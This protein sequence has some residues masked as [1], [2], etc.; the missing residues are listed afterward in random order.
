METRMDAEEHAKFRRKA[1]YCHFSASKI[2]EAARDFF[3]AAHETIHFIG[4]FYILVEKMDLTLD[5]IRKISGELA[6]PR[7]PMIVYKEAVKPYKEISFDLM[8]ARLIDLFLNYLSELFALIYISK[9]EM[10]RS[11]AEMKVDE[12]LEH[13]TMDELIES[14]AEKKVND[15]AYLGFVKLN[16]TI[17]SQ[18]GESLVPDPSDYREMILAIEF[19]NLFVHNKGIAN[20]TYLNRVDDNSVVLGQKVTSLKTTWMDTIAKIVLEIDSRFAD[21]FAIE[22]ITS[23]SPHLCYAL[24]TV[25]DR[26]SEA[27]TLLSKP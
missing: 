2:T 12:I 11:S 23:Y 1:V 14:I 27:S 10:L 19:R 22:R 24:G 4:A 7:K 25:P 9:P 15:L 26:T 16:K 20:M 8:H 6:I 18:M 21:K 17:E 13:S 5:D 3:I